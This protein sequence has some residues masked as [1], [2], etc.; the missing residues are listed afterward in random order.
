MEPSKVVADP[1]PFPLI[2]LAGAPY[3][4][5]VQYGRQASAHIRRTLALYGPA[6]ERGGLTK[7]SIAKIAGRY[8]KRID[9]YSTDMAAE[10]AG[11]ADGADLRLVDIVAINARTELLYS[12]APRVRKSLGEEP[13]DG[14]TGAIALPAACADGRVIHG[15]NWDWRDECK[16]TTVVLRIRPE[17]GPHILTMVEAGMLGR[18]G[19]NSAGVALT[20]NYLQCE[21]DFSAEGVPLPLVRRS[22][23]EAPSLRDA[24]FRIFNAPRSFSANMMLS[25]AGGE[26]VNLE[27][28]PQDVFWLMPERGLM[29]HANHFMSIGALAK[30]RDIGLLVT[31]DSL[32]RVTRVRS[33]LERDHGALKASDFVA[34]FADRYGSPYAVCRTSVEDV[35]R[36]KKPSTVATIIM[37][38]QARRMWIAPT[39]Y[40]HERAAYW[41]YDFESAS[42]TRSDP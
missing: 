19:M 34:A 2:E 22:A 10:L 4:R 25:E 27:T 7:S 42:P 32:Y 6:F 41:Q 16:D 8:L 1:A 17:Q 12:H 29:V 18:C 31:P 11:I 15:Q 21:Q 28:T 39:P 36:G 3:D 35:A 9:L 14:C 38:T 5:G 23:L 13:D 26:G 40:L 33:R 30:L 24:M 20:G 37:D